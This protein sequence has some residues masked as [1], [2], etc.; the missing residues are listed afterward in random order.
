MY[1]NLQDPNSESSSDANN[2]PPIQKHW[3]LLS[4]ETYRKQLV[5]ENGR[6]IYAVNN[7]M[8]YSIQ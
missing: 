7:N 4:G 3:K 8:P 2:I 1:P 6:P 5:D